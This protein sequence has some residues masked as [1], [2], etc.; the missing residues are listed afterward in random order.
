VHGLLALIVFKFRP[1]KIPFC[2]LLGSFSF[3]RRS[4][5]NDL[6]V[7]IILWLCAMITLGSLNTTRSVT[8]AIVTHVLPTVSVARSLFALDLKRMKALHT[9]M[10]LALA[11][12]K[13]T[14]LFCM[15][16]AFA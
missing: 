3:G 8:E 7:S 9:R 16:N 11:F 14:H 2:A 4:I 15:R 1:R 12:L 5:A 6:G 10:Q 13:S